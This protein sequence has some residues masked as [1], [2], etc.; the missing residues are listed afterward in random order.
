LADNSVYAVAVD[1]QGNK[2]F[3]TE[4]G[5]SK[6]DGRT[7]T[8]YDRNNS[9]L[10]H[11]RVYSIAIDAQG[12]KWF[13]TFDGVSKF[14]GRIWTHYNSNNSGLAYDQV[15]AIA[16]DAQGNKWFGIHDGVSKFDGTNWTTYNSRNS[17][18]SRHF[19]VTVTADS[20]G[21][22]WFGSKGGGVTKFDGTNWTVYKVVNSRVGSNDIRAMLVEGDDKWFVGFG[23][24]TK[25]SGCTAPQAHFT[26]AR[27]SNRTFQFT[28]RSL[29]LLDPTYEW[30]FGDG[31]TASSAHPTVTYAQSGNYVVQLVVKNNGVCAHTTRQLLQGVSTEEMEAISL[32]LYPN[33]VTTT[34]MVRA[35]ID[36][37]GQMVNS[38]GQLVV[39][40]IS[41]KV[42]ENQIIL[43]TLPKG[44]YYLKY[45]G[46]ATRFFKMD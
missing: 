36:L 3:G 40:N 16:I 42:G 13:G 44:I 35:P 26:V 34:L 27:G 24:I 32:K 39:Q 6:F 5:V 8:N 41:L 30:T 4:N 37:D 20:Q 11:Y 29:N 19:V 33:P 25:W 31:Q 46:G 18:L 1:T 21:N 2:W 12:T 38:L 15:I 22:M 7:W 43:P 10:P 28:N 14:D 9:G 23:A 17:G 45:Q